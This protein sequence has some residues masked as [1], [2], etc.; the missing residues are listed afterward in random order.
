[1]LERCCCSLNEPVVLR[2]F[3]PLSVIG[4]PVLICTY[5]VHH[6]SIVINDVGSNSSSNPTK[7]E[8]TTLSFF[9]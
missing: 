1:M 4:M 5:I 9:H 6:R 8:S 2:Y 3:V 7:K